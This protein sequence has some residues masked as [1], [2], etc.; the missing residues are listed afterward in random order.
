MRTLVASMLLSCA[1]HVDAPAAVVARTATP[2]PTT[3]DAPVVDVPSSEE[4]A[5]P[6]SRFATRT[7]GRED[8]SPRWVGRPIDLD[9]K[10]ADV[11][12]VCRLL[13]D[14]GR[15]NIVLGDGVQGQVTLRMHRVPWDQAFDA[16]LAAK[17][18][19]AERDG[20]VILVFNDSRGAR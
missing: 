8:S 18:L 19:R 4:S 15:V 14:V 11:A 6:S 7:I 17:G 9:L 2:A 1:A 3:V 5:P 13:A 16:V 20:N 10:D 12:N